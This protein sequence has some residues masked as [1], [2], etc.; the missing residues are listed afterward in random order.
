MASRSRTLALALAMAGAALTASAQQM[1]KAGLGIEGVPASQSVAEADARLAEVAQERAAVEAEFA[2]N[3]QACYA[4]FFVNYCLDGAREKRRTALAPLRKVEIEAAYF[5]RADAVDKRDRE[6][7]EQ[8][9]LNQADAAA[10]AQLPPK[11]RVVAPEPQP[12]AGGKSLEERQAEFDAR[13]ARRQAQEA[14]EAPMRQGKEAA[15]E[16][17]QREAAERQHEI[18]VKQAEKAAAAEAAAAAAKK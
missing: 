7:A 10:R 5:K 14:A 18:A 9:K 17:K 11:V 12:R 8:Q 2:Q 13:N 16:R 15:F 6:L 4:R 3:E 1:G